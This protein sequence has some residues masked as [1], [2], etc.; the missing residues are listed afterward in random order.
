MVSRRIRRQKQR[1]HSSTTGQNIDLLRQEARDLFREHYALIV[2]MQIVTCQNYVDRN[3]IRSRIESGSLT[4]LKDQNDRTNQIV[5]KIR[6]R[7]G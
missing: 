6:G 7:I 2:L 4:W 1:T 5:G 3:A